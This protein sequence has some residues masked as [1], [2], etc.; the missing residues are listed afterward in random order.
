MHDAAGEPYR[1]S[2]SLTDIT[3]RK[4][5]EE[6]SLQDVLYDPRT[7]LPTHSILLDRLDQAL[8][9]KTRRPDQA[10]AVLCV[11]I[12]GMEAAT[13]IFYGDNSVTGER[14]VRWRNVIIHEIAHQWW[15]NAVTENDWDH[16]WLS[17]GFATYFTL[18]YREYAYG[19]DDFLDGLARS[20]QTIIDF[21]TDNPDYRVVHDNLDDMRRVT[22]G[23]T[24]QKGGWFLHMLRTDVED[25]FG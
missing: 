3:D 12:Q 9:R 22:N 10:S 18:L 6:R 4:R 14:T 16:V 8:R 20:R 24:Y 19:R 1:I 23:M 5:E 2:G 21:Y 17:E 11:S 25:R 7:G 13:A 15:G